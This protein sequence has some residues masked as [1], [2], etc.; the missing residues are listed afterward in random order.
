MRFIHVAKC[1]SISFIFIFEYHSVVWIYHHLFNCLPVDGHLGWFHLGAIMAKAAMDIYQVFGWTWFLFFNSIRQSLSLT[2]KKFYQ[3][4][5][6]QHCID[7]ICIFSQTKCNNE[8]N[9]NSFQSSHFC[10]LFV[11]LF[12]CFIFL[13]L[14]LS[15]LNEFCIYTSKFFLLLVWQLYM[16]F[17]CSVFPRDVSILFNLMKS[18]SI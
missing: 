1:I 13:L 2:K 8:V 15:E 17:S 14:P 10:F 11:L 12:L 7:Y 4:F 5:C 6:L 9:L 16:L 18:Y 3:F